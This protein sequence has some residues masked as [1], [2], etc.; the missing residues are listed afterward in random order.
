ME[1]IDSPQRL[2]GI[3]EEFKKTDFGITLS[4]RVRYEKYKPAEVSNG[5]WVELL[6][7]DVN[8][9]THLTL[10]YGLVQNFVRATD[11]L[12]PGYL[13]EE[14]D[15]VLKVA[16]LI[17]D[18][19]EAIVGDISYGDKT[20]IDELQEQAAFEAHLAQFYDGDAANLIDKARKEVV[21][22]H[23]G[24]SK[25]GKAFNAIERVGYLRTALRAS[26]HVIDQDAPDC[27][28]GLRWIVADVLSQ[29]PSALEHYSETLIA[30][31]QYLI[32]EHERISRAFELIDNDPS[33]FKNY[34][35][36][37]QVVKESQFKQSYKDWD[38][39]IKI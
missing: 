27:D 22:D 39:R 16:A 4:S 33:V 32:A 26:D 19:A 12:Q 18:W 29:Q 23:M 38:A 17:H 30:I 37:Q 11:M 28:A 1:R 6:G 2:I 9:L 3:H 5:R 31:K 35:I 13:N 7:A 10:T 20:D 25:L 8:N 14:E 21:F 36:D 34:P 15:E 24:N